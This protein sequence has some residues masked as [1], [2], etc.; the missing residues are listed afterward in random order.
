MNMTIPMYTWST[1]EDWLLLGLAF[2]LAAAA[3]NS[4]WYLAFPLLLVSAAIAGAYFSAILAALSIR[5]SVGGL[6]S[7]RLTTS[8][9]ERFEEAL[10]DGAGLFCESLTGPDLNMLPTTAIR[11]LLLTFWYNF[12]S[13]LPRC[14]HV[15]VEL[16]KWKYQHRQNKR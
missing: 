10:D 7:A 1:E 8:V 12:I 4:A 13:K 9:V 2:S 6:S 3:A 16:W 11:E 14:S 5:C 15:E